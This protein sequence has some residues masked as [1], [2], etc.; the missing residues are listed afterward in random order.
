MKITQIRNATIMLEINQQRILLDPMLAKQSSLPKLRYFRSQERNP[1]VELPE[2]FQQ[3]K[4]SIDT[5]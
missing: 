5:P 3:V 2:M 4:D 1:L